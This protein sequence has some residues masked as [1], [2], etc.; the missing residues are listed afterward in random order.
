MCDLLCTILTQIDRAIT[1]L[2]EAT[3]VIPMDPAKSDLFTPTKIL[4]LQYLA[5]YTIVSRD[6]HFIHQLIKVVCLTLV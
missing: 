2:Q 3:L 4:Y 6:E 5:Q 1:N